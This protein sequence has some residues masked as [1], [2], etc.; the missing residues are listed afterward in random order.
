MTNWIPLE[1]DHYLDPVH[2][3]TGYDRPIDWQLDYAPW[4]YLYAPG[5][6]EL[7]MRALGVTT[8]AGLQKRARPFV[9]LAIMVVPP[10]LREAVKE[11]QPQDWTKLPDDQIRNAWDADN[12]GFAKV[13]LSLILLQV[14]IFQK[15]GLIGAKLNLNKSQL[16]DAEYERLRGELQNLRPAAGLNVFEEIKAHLATYAFLKHENKFWKTTVVDAE[17]TARNFRSETFQFHME[18]LPSFADGELATIET[19]V[20]IRDWLAKKFPD[21]DPGRIIFVHAQERQRKVRACRK[22]TVKPKG[23]ISESKKS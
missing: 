12:M 7:A 18:F 20:T 17:E 14:L 4:K 6:K 1:P 5:F 10:K 8:C 15:Q 22:E 23:K 19:L 16:S 21:E 11:V 9:P 2:F 13:V 3:G